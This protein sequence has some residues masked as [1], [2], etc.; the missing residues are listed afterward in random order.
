MALD[1][2]PLAEASVYPAQIFGPLPN[3]TVLSSDVSNGL[4][5]LGN[6]TRYLTDNK[7]STTGGTLT[8]QLTVTPIAADEAI[9]A[10]GGTGKAG[11]V[12]TNGTTQT[13]AAPTNAAQFGGYVQLTGAD[14]NPGVDPGANDALHAANIIKAWG[15]VS[16]TGGTPFA[17]QD[18]YNVTDVTEPVANIYQ[19]NF[20]RAFSNTTYSVTFTP[21]APGIGVSLSTKTTTTCRFNVWDTTAPGTPVP[22]QTVDFIAVGRQ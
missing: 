10:S 6:R 12:A 15:T 5:K 13:A 22:N 21:H 2:T 19:I 3:S 17:T 4:E 20:V 7:L 1:P 18:D 9:I 14:P 16:L 8:G 11:L